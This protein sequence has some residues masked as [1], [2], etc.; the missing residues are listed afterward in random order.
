MWVAG[1]II[2]KNKKKGER[3]MFVLLGY[4]NKKSVW[5]ADLTVFPV[6]ME[7]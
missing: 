6:C 4:T 1:S 3:N 5:G 7:T 2:L